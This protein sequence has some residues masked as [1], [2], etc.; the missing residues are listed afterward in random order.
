MKQDVFDLAKRLPNSH[1]LKK[2]FHWRV[3]ADIRH[4]VDIPVNYK[5]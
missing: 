2:K 1:N 4:A 5:S 3:R